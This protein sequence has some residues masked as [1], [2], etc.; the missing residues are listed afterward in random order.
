MGIA[1]LKGNLYLFE[2]GRLRRF[3]FYLSQVRSAN[4]YLPDVAVDTRPFVRLFGN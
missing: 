2:E 4:K 3:V 1:V